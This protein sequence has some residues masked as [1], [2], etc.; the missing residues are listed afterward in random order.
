MNP[1][2]FFPPPS[3]SLSRVNSRPSSA[4]N[5][6]GSGTGLSGAGSGGGGG[7]NSSSSST[8]SVR[9]TLQPL[10]TTSSRVGSSSKIQTLSSNNNNNTN[11]IGPSGGF[12]GEIHSSS[13]SASASGATT[14]E[15]STGEV[16]NGATRHR[17]L[18]IKRPVTSPSSPSISSEMLSPR[19]KAVAGDGYSSD[20]DVKSGTVNVTR[21]G[22]QSGTSSPR[23]HERMSSSQQLKRQLTN[24][25]TNTTH[26]QSTGGR[27][28][29]R[30]PAGLYFDY[31]RAN[32]IGHAHRIET[33]SYDQDDAATL[34]LLRYRQKAAPHLFLG[35]FI[36]LPLPK[37]SGPLS[38]SGPQPRKLIAF[39]SGSA[40]SALT[41]RAMKIH[42][43]DEFA[44]LVCLW[45]VCVA[46]EYR[47]KGL[48]SKL[49]EEY[50]RRL[51]RAEEGEK[52]K[53]YECVALI[54][55]EE[56]IPLFEKA[57]FKK[58][59]VSHVNV[60][61]GGWFELRRY[62]SPRD[63]DDEEDD[64]NSNGSGSDKNDIRSPLQLSG[65]LSSEGQA[66]VPMDLA[67][68]GE[69]VATTP[70][71]ELERRLE[72][73]VATIPT[74]EDE[75]K[76]LPIKSPNLF[77]SDSE[78]SQEA[79]ELSKSP[80]EMSPDMITFSTSKNEKTASSEKDGEAL[81]G[82]SPSGQSSAFSS[83]KIMEALSK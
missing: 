36:P 3:R 19:L 72:A 35:A 26:T 52:K 15:R 71:Q 63:H 7:T 62:I 22:S 34:E 32:E 16:V 60:G 76:G 77:I 27:L 42:S 10:S 12:S 43:D 75:A 81:N 40:S 25:S 23:R 28:G 13:S 5:N 56:S 66:H 14:P 8:K 37:V 6:S 4:N 21:N 61:S 9:R 20:S 68:K 65:F 48:G 24:S 50:I 69:E 59:G 57:A 38:M 82:I 44:W 83:A 70:T 64:N 11:T 53:G 58:L 73:H 2:T 45:S 80:A 51:R 74:S 41:A 33:Q 49:I 39:A 54:T 29:H 18:S 31:V 67:E 55:H 47:R 1:L 17:Q 79:V 46:S 78:G 30:L